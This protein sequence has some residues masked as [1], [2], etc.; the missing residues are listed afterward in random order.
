MTLKVQI[1]QT[2]RMLFIILVG[3]MMT[4]FSEKMQTWFDAQLDLK[5]LEGI[6]LLHQGYFQEDNW[7]DAYRILR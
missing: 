4:R 6:Y 3:L 1:L 5:I 2:L 7:C